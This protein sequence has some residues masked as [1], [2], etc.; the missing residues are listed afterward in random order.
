MVKYFLS[1]FPLACY[2]L[3]GEVVLAA[4]WR[5]HLG[6][7]G[8]RG[9]GQGRRVQ[10]NPEPSASSEENGE[11]PSGVFFSLFVIA[12]FLCTPEWFF[13][14]ILSGKFCARIKRRC[15]ECGSNSDTAVPTG[16]STEARSLR[17][18]SWG[19]RSFF[20]FYPVFLL[21][22]SSATTI[23]QLME[24]VGGVQRVQ[25]WQHAERVPAW[26]SQLAALQLVQQVI[27]THRVILHSF[28]FEAKV[29][30]GLVS[31]GTVHG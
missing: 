14:F 29:K 13:H 4:L 16:V 24:E 5:R 3:L 31:L 11:Q 19:F 8:G 12:W 1:L 6:T 23:C 27:V 7:E 20:Y 17:P 26:R 21:S 15:C 10:K 2:L 30:L 9:R 22:L 25:E 28:C 18:K